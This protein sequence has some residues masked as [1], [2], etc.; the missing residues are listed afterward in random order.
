MMATHAQSGSGPTF[1]FKPAPAA[2][3]FGAPF[4]GAFGFASA[5]AYVPTAGTG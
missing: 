4:G 3:F 2:P 1:F 5:I